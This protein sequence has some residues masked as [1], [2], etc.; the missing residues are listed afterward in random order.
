[1]KYLFK[2]SFKDFKNY[3][4]NL[5]FCKKYIFLQNEAQKGFK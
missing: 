4:L 1:M 2:S 3:N 5:K